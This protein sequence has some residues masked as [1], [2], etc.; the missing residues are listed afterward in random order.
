MHR[1]VVC[2]DG[3]WQDMIADSNVCRLTKAYV[4]AAGDQPAH[5][6]RGVGTTGFAVAKLQAAVTAAGL[7]GSLLDGYGWLVEHFRPG[8]RIALFGFSRGAYAARSLAGMIGRVGL[9]DGSD[10]DADGRAAAV[11]RAY[12][13]YRALRDL[14][15]DD[16]WSAGLRFAYTAGD[17]D[18]PIDFI[19]V[20]DTVGAL[21]IPAYIGVPDFQH[22][23]TRYEFLDV[24]L[25]PRIPHARHAVALDEMRGPFRPTLWSDPAAGQDMRQVWFPGDHC[26][27][28]GGH[29]E[30]QLS[31]AALEWMTQEAAAAVGLTFDLAQVD[32]FDPSPEGRAHGVADGLKGAVLEIGYQ[33]RPRAVPRVDDARPDSTVSD[34]ARERQ[35]RTG[36]RT[37]VTLAVGDTMTV[38]VEADRAWTDTGLYLEVG[39]YK[40]S[41]SGRW[42]S[43]LNSSGPDGEAGFLHLSGG[44]FSSI[45]DRIEGGVRTVLNNKEAELVGTRRDNDLPWMSLV[46]RVGNEVTVPI[47]GA[48]PPV[49]T[50]EVLPDERLPLGA[51]CTMSVQRP[52]YLYAYP[53]DALGF[54]GNNSGAVRMTVTRTG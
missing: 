48:R 2:C 53:N 42:S 35:R 36:Y 16:T 12:S 4:P 50:I 22:S 3:T 7:D 46:G 13:R 28:G 45:V 17:D 32:D 40:F 9:V 39:E 51:A 15:V 26:D 6:V 14:P 54:Y 23:R 44:L 34:S 18:I 38:T 5:Y 21:G 49:P 25:N 20:W 37:T 47:K 29:A 10:L 1:L 52:G 30:K 41:A 11:G 8:D 33:P 19:G 43:A 27:V 24:E 31:D